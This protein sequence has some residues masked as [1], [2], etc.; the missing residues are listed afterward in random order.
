MID[1][2]CIALFFIRNELTALSTFT[3]HLMMM[4]MMMMYTGIAQ[5]PHAIVASFEACCQWAILTVPLTKHY[6]TI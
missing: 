1:N 5:S 6:P 2:F 4:M 3:Q